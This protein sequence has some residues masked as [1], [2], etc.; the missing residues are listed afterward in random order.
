M[1]EFNFSPSFLLRLSLANFD[2]VSE[3]M[4][5]LFRSYTTDSPL[6]TDAINVLIVRRQAFYDSY[7]RS[8]RKDY[9]SHDLREANKLMGKYMVTIRL[10]L[11]GYTFLPPEEPIRR[12]AEL[13]LLPFK[14]FRYDTSDGNAAE[15][16]KVLAITRI[17]AR[18]T[19]YSLSEF[20]VQ[21][22]ADRAVEYANK[23]EELILLRIKHTA[24]RIKGDVKMARHS[25]YEALC[26]CITLVHSM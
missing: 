20:H 18:S 11:K 21:Q 26:K 16:R 4:C 23:V 7:D 3:Q 9:T 2:G 14:D 17:W 1:N 10:K 5:Q 12:K 19:E 6:L 25:L 8:R 22:F 15:A 13:A 24:E